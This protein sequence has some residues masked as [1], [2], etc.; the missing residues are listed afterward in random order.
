MAPEVRIRIYEA[1]T[2]LGKLCSDIY[3]S[4]VLVQ[5]SQLWESLHEVKWF[6]SSCAKYVILAPVPSEP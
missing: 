4:W 2:M 3:S 6:R 1:L 5:I